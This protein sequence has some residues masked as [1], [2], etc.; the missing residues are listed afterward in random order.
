MPPGECQSEPHLLHVRH[1]DRD[2]TTKHDNN[3]EILSM[4]IRIGETIRDCRLKSCTH[5]CRQKE[6]SEAMSKMPKLIEE[7]RVSTDTSADTDYES[8]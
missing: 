6:I 7:Y 3:I 2:R 1:R 4:D 5:V 8:S